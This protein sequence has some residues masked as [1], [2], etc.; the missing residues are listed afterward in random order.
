MHAFCRDCIEAWLKKE[1][2]CPMCRTARG[3][4]ESY[5]LMNNRESETIEDIKNDLT[6]ELTEIINIIVK[7][8]TL[9]SF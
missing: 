1:A 8:P 2:H 9:E 7:T 3:S 4:V 6:K 5:T